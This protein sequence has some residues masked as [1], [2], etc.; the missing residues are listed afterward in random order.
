MAV[1]TNGYIITKEIINKT[2]IKTGAINDKHFILRLVFSIS[3]SIG[4]IEADKKN[5]KQPNIAIV[6]IVKPVEESSHKYPIAVWRSCKWEHATEQIVNT[7]KPGISFLKNLI[8]PSKSAEKEIRD[9]IK[10]IISI[11]KLS[12]N[13][14]YA[15]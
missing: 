13:I 10:T 6:E 4:P 11:I 8:I 9:E 12:M 5:I 2:A 1:S 7:K 15:I 14:L 3:L